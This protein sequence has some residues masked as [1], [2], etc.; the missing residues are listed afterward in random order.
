MNFLDLKIV[1]DAIAV[2]GK[3]LSN[4]TFE[5]VFSNGQKITIGFNRRIILSSLG[6]KGNLREK[7]DDKSIKI[8]YNN[9]NQFQRSKII[10]TAEVMKAIFDKG[11]F[12]SLNSIV[13]LSYD[14]FENRLNLLVSINNGES[15]GSLSINLFNKQVEG[16]ELVDDVLLSINSKKFTIPISMKCILKIPGLKEKVIVDD[17]L[18]EEDILKACDASSDIA[19]RCDAV[20]TDDPI[21]MNYSKK[22]DDKVKKKNKKRKKK[23]KN[24]QDKE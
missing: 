10:K 12:E 7:P 17:A 1:K 21:Q 11:N 6:F 20:F 15:Y 8:N 18:S 2:C 4:K 22:M 9:L 14:D 5:F 23:K 13:L 16:F 19:I 3:N 24:N